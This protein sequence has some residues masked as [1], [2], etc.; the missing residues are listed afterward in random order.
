MSDRTI[1]HV[2]MNAFFASV[3]QKANPHLLGKSILVCGNPKGRTVVATASY[4]ARKFG[5]KT[6]MTI[7][8]AKRLCPDAILVECDPDKYVDTATKLFNIYIDFTPQVEVFS[9]DEAFLD[10][11]GTERLFGTPVE[12]AQKI[13]QKIRNELGLPCSIGIGPNKL[14]AKFASESKKPDGLT[15]LTKDKVLEI[16]ENVPISELCGI[17]TKMTQHLNKFGIYTCGQLGRYPFEILQRRFG[18]IGLYLHHMGLGEDESPV[19]YYY[20]K[21]PVKSMGHSLTLQEDAHDKEIVKRHLLQLSEKVGR[22]MRRENY[23]GRT[24]TLI[25]RYADFETVAK[26]HTLKKFIDDGKLIY[27]ATL[28]ILD[29]LFIQHR[30]V[31]LTG[32]SVSNLVQG[33]KQLNV[34]PEERRRE[35]LLYALDQIND[36]FG[37][38]TITY[39]KL[40]EPTREGN[41]IS[42]AWR[43]HKH[44]PGFKVAT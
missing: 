23:Q 27:K 3:E 16:L 25:L 18:I 29:T 19:R 4:E 6:G 2:D 31:R 41:V 39:A 43:P 30:G 42:P 22:R 14:L 40:L 10:I 15:V 34:L 5:I 13:K 35:G 12:I 32:V 1:L 38:F 8:Q 26:Q 11:T 21:E 37:E 28:G 36:K 7:Y 24:V 44:I 20:E 33:A 9:I 17:G